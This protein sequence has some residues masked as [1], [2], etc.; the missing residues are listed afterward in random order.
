MQLTTLFLLAILLP[1]NP[2]PQA[3][4]PAPSNAESV[5]NGAKL[6]GR[7]CVSC[8]GKEGKGDGPAGAK[9]K[10]PPSNLADAEWKHGSSD[11]EILA[12]IHDGV[13]DTGMKGFASRMT[14]RELQD[15]VSYVKSLSGGPK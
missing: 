7:Y 13:K 11:A 2:A 8:H 1:R 9:L 5:A 6:F 15:L 12:V 14:E 3:Q 10:P 4:G